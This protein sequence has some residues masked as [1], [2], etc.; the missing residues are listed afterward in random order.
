MDL[1][2]LRT[3]ALSVNLNAH[4]VDA[5]VTRPSPDDTPITTRA[6]W[7]GPLEDVQPY[8]SDFRQRAPRKVLVLPRA[9]VP[10]IPTGTIIAAAEAPGGE[11]KTWRFEGHDGPAQADYWRVTVRAQL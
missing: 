7:S 1:G 2:P 9:D 5:T 11:V 10:T 4:G 3:L 8:G 6:I